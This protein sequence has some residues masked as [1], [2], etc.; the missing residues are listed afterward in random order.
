[1]DG[2]M[3]VQGGRISAGPQGG[4]G[5]WDEHP[6]GL[7]VLGLHRDTVRKMLAFSVPPGC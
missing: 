4:D 7:R 3:D 6:G 1:M 2:G 5:G